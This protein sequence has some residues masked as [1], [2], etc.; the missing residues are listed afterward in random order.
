[1][2]RDLLLTTRSDPLLPQPQCPIYL[3][4]CRLEEKK[5]TKD[6]KKEVTGRNRRKDEEIRKM[7]CTGQERKRNKEEQQKEKP[8]VQEEKTGQRG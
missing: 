7:M 6:S 4:L 3:S 1:M 2:H 5:R 8:R